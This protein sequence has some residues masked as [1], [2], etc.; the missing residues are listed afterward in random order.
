MDLQYGALVE[1]KDNILLG[2][3]DHIV[4]DT[5][6]GEQRKFVVRRDAPQ[7]DIFFSPKHVEKTTNEKV[8]LNL[9]I[10]E[11]EKE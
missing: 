9:S 8:K 7:T 5:W 2:K 11:L 1:D 10:S 3:I 4:L 6:T